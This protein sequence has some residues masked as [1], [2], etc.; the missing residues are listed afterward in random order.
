P[1]VFVIENNRYSMGT[2][3]S[4]TLPVEDITSRAPGYGMVGDRF[5][6]T[7]PFQVRDRIG[8]AIK[9]AREESQPT[10]VEVLTYRFRGHSMSDPAKYRQKGELEAFRSR[11]PLELTRRSLVEIHGMSEDDLEALDETIVEE[12]D[13]AVEF[14]DASP[15]PDPEHRFR[16]ILIEDNQEQG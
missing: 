10:L 1:V 11:D 13:A 2:P 7:D 8:A 9:R 6:V 14:A 12:M 5:E 3:L 16:N 4:R 15:Q